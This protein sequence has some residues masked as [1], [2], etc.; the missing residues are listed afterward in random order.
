[1]LFFCSAEDGAQNLVCAKQAL[2][3]WSYP[4]PHLCKFK[5]THQ[6][7]IF[8]KDTYTLKKFPNTLEKVIQQKR[9]WTGTGE[10][11]QGA[12]YTERM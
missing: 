1:M 2:Y 11:K 12:L 9:G 3:H 4:Q 7:N 8:N 6:L 5:A 10:N